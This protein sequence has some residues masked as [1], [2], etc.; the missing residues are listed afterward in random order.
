MLSVV[1]PVGPLHRTLVEGAFFPPFP[2]TCLIS[3][4]LPLGIAVCRKLPTPKAPSLLEV[5][6]PLPITT[7]KL[8]Q[9]VPAMELERKAAHLLLHKSDVTR[10]VCLS[11][12]RDVLDNLDG[13]K[14]ILRLFRELFAPGANYS[15]S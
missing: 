5:G 11:V 15:I 8:R 6:A 13:A 3:F 1:L 7:K 14:Q 2:K 12:G 10:K 9:R 4:F